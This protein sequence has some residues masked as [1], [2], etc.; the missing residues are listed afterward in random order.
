[1]ARYPY[2]PEY[3]HDFERL[4]GWLEDKLFYLYEAIK[5]KQYDRVRVMSGE[6]IIT[7]SEIAEHAIPYVKIEKRRKRIRRVRRLK[8]Q[9]D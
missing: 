2:R 6:V 7:A 8:G 4:Y 1:M 9:G 5:L 3:P